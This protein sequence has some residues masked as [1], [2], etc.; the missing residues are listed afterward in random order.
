MSSRKHSNVS[1]PPPKKKFGKNLHSAHVAASSTAGASV[2]GRALPPPP[3]ASFL[4][5]SS[6][7]T[8]SNTPQYLSGI[9]SSKITK[10]ETIVQS[11]TTGGGGLLLLSTKKS[12]SSAVNSSNNRNV[13]N[14]GSGGNGFMTLS[15]SSS[16]SN[17]TKI[18]KGNSTHDALVNALNGGDRQDAVQEKVPSAWGIQAPISTVLAANSGSEEQ[19]HRVQNNV[20][21]NDEPTVANVGG[22]EKEKSQNYRAHED[23]NV[24]DEDRLVEES[25]NEKN[26][27]VLRKN[28]TEHTV[29]DEIPTQREPQSYGNAVSTIDTGSEVAIAT[30]STA[31]TAETNPATVS[32]SHSATEDGN[33]DQLSSPRHEGFSENQ[34]EFMKKLAKERA[35]KRRQEEKE[36]ESLLK[37][38]AMQ[39]LHELDMKLKLEKERSQ[40]HRQQQQPVE[41]GQCQ[42]QSVSSKSHL[43]PSI[44]GTV[45][46]APVRQLYDPKKTYSSLLGGGQATSKDNPIYSSASTTVPAPASLPPALSISPQTTQ[47]TPPENLIHLNSYEDQNRGIRNTDAGP[48]MLFDPKSGSM[49]AA[50][51]LSKEKKATKKNT[52]RKNSKDVA[53]DPSLLK[54]SSKKENNL[55][56]KSVRQSEKIREHASKRN[57]KDLDDKKLAPK[58]ES[59]ALKSQRVLPRTCGVLYK[60]N[61]NGEIV[62][63]DGCDGDRGYGAHSVPGGRIKNPKAYAVIKQKELESSRHHTKHPRMKHSID[64]TSN[65]QNYGQGLTRS[66]F[67]RKTSHQPSN[68]TDS[69]VPS[70]I[71]EVLRGDEK[72]DLLSNLEASPKLQATAAA[73]APSQAVLALTA[74]N[75]THVSRDAISSDHDGDMESCDQISESGV[76]AMN[77]IAL[78]DTDSVQDILEHGEPSPSIDLGL[79]FDPSKNMDSLM[80]SPA[81]G[82]ETPTKLDLADLKLKESPSQTRSTSNPFIA[83]NSILGSSTWGTGGNNSST[84]G[85]LSNWDLLGSKS[86]S[87]R[88]NLHRDNAP[89]TFLS[90]GVSGDQATWSNSHGTPFGGFN[91]IDT[92]S[93]GSSD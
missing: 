5:Y 45:R 51:T 37:E 16:S 71:V 47:P 26:D 80:M 27:D 90:L 23:K 88:V 25:K 2:V 48:R 55:Y 10:R 86:S 62:S 12:A 6:S 82:A 83:S 28:E 84:M 54:I 59:S 32:T 79:G 78:I 1:L 89:K 31:S 58:S 73:W 36:R 39:R 19:I 75:A 81:T 18:V 85:S 68:S 67:M 29:Q 30:S 20:D 76:H 9:K 14:Y 34:V 60:Y 42:Q 61:E 38:R 53:D 64:A 33:F 17:K 8:S 52:P 63:A 72:L 15:S 93:V 56:G 46:V 43:N 22:M 66:H 87:Q 40:Q 50:P 41:E 44:D 69:D 57:L 13:G 70:S 49:V 24:A 3:I 92:P 74:T 21:H 7:S 11:S 4:P 35:E 65:E 91:S 77:A